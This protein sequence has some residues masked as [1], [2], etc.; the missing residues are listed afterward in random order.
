MIGEARK[1]SER[2]GSAKENNW[3]GK[4]TGKEKERRKKRHR[5]RE[6]GYEDTRVQIEFEISIDGQLNKK[7]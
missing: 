6:N 1:S 5:P 2:K 4:G 7:A 3:E